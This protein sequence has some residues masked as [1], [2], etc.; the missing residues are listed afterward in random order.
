MKI[1][2]TIFL[3]VF[4]FVSLQLSAQD[5]A[6]ENNLFV[7]NAF[8][9]P[10]LINAQTTVMPALHGFEF[11]IRHR[12][13]TVRPDMD[14]VKNFF[15]LD[16]VA[17]IRFGFIVPVSSK[18][19]V[20]AGRTKNGKTYDLE[21]KYLL[22]SQTTDGTTPVSVALYADAAANTDDFLP[23]PKYAYFENGITPFQYKFNHRLAYNS[24][25]II[26]RTFGENL[27]LQVT[28]TII[29]HNLVSPGVDNRTI[30]LP[31]SGAFKTGIN[32]SFLFEYAYRFN[33]K[34]ADHLYPISAAM[35][36]GTAGHIFQLVLSSSQELLE[37][38]LY[39]NPVAD[40]RNG[41]FM[42][43]FNIKRTFWNKK[44]IQ[45]QQ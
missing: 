23:I 24:Q 29:H 3:S 10:G 33:N 45:P 22:F 26:S 43:G 35:E 17:N 32:S 13:G 41:K 30:A 44:K 6:L 28:P 37:Q 31:V 7:T 34:P 1:L 21:A 39:T 42:L 38:H 25:V 15:G 12:F 40:Y 19:Y 36:F 9:S 11:S 8:R 16:L 2:Y 27:S 14:A 18:M 4:F 20:G 5:L